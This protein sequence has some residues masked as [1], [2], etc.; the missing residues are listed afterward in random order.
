MEKNMIFSEVVKYLNMLNVY[1]KF[2][3]SRNN[4]YDEFVLFEY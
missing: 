4:F 3:N 1:D 2:R